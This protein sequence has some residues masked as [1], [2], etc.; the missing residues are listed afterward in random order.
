[1]QEKVGQWTFNLKLFTWFIHSV[2]S[3]SDVCFDFLSGAICL[4]L[5]HSKQFLKVTNCIY[6]STLLQLISYMA[7]LCDVLSMLMC[8]NSHNHRVP[9]HIHAF[10][11][12]LSPALHRL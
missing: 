11:M 7:N 9:S 4:K 3:P 8:S 5:L 2:H 1:M 10:I 6:N 12:L